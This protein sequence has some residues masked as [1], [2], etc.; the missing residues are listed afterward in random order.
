MSVPEPESLLD[1]QRAP[2]ILYQI[3][4]RPLGYAQRDRWFELPFESPSAE[5]IL[6]PPFGG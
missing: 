5:F 4:A 3:Q 2:G 6:N 1:F